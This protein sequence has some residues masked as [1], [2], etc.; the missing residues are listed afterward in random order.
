MVKVANL[1]SN[2]LQINSGVPQ[3]GSILGPLLF[4]VYV[5]DLTWTCPE[6]DINL[7]AD[8][9]TMYKSGSDLIQIQNKLQENLFS[10]T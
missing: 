4:L 1:N 6:V 10:C 8:D 3:L 5:N 9:S 2:M 7:Y